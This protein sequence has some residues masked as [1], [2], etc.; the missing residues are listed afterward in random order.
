[1]LIKMRHAKGATFYNPLKIDYIDV[2]KDSIH[3]S[4][5][6]GDKVFPRK[7]NEAAVL[8]LEDLG[9]LT[10]V[11]QDGLREAIQEGMQSGILDAMRKARSELPPSV[12][13][14]PR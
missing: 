3:I 6:G 2:D 10:A 1:M 9:V 5:A 11:M 12:R 7:G 14:G 13:K 8:M 4:S